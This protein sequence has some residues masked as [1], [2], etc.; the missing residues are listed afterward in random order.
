MN[1]M[2]NLYRMQMLENE[3]EPE[4]TRSPYVNDLI[5]LVE[6]IKAGTKTEEDLSEAVSMLSSLFDNLKTI[7]DYLKQTQPPSDNFEIKYS[8]LQELLTLT[9]EEMSKLSLYF[10]DCNT[11][12]LDLPI[13]NIKKYIAEIFE[14]TDDFKKIEDSQPI[15]AGS[16]QINELIRVGKGYCA[17]DFSLDAFKSRY[18]LASKTIAETHEQVQVLAEQP[19]D[20]KALEESMPDIL[21]N[22]DLMLKAS[23]SIGKFID[24]EPSSDDK[25]KIVQELEKIREASA[26][27]SEIQEKINKELEKIA[28]EKTK[29][30]CPRCGYKTSAYESHCEKCKMLLPPLP[31]GYLPEHA[32]LDVVA[33]SDGDV[34]GQVSQ[35]SNSNAERLVTPN[36]AKVYDAALKVGNGQ[37]PKEE[38][39]K[40][41][42]WYGSLVDQ[43]KKDIEKI[44]EPDNLTEEEK[45]VFDQAFNLFK[46][47]VSGSE[48]GL[49]ELI[50]YFADDN[51]DHLVKGVNT[52]I[53]AGEKM[54]QLEA[55]G[56]I[57]KE[58]IKRGGAPLKD[59][60]NEAEQEEPADNTLA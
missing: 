2:K 7:A 15:Y 22:M 6:E 3:Q 58:R 12:Y 8:R 23:D 54:Y 21:K 59:E 50:E 40:V 60:S 13:E 11:E 48:A 31:E 10:E 49:N 19:A 5:K 51:T 1:N 29:R 44:Q 26:N 34:K 55:I 16:L 38:F 42:E 37:I 24:G 47:G 9:E 36:V 4:A 35:D 28:E 56:D 39:G 41:I 20:T 33:D 30:L 17:G 27:I 18:D 57:M 14:I 45:P 52:L 25:K 46:E 32:A 53:E 43:A